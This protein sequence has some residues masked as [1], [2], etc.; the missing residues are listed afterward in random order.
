MFNAQEES[1]STKMNKDKPLHEPDEEIISEQLRDAMDVLEAYNRPSPM[2]LKAQ[3]Q[4][5]NTTDNNLK[6]DEKDLSAISSPIYSQQWT[7]KTDKKPP[8]GMSVPKSKASF[9][10]LSKENK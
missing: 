6:F 5:S 7:G 3:T 1:S 8:T 2:D 9:K 4:V 10:N